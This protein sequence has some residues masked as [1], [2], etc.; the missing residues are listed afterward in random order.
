MEEKEREQFWRRKG[1]QGGWEWSKGTHQRKFVQCATKAWQNVQ[2]SCK[3]NRE[4]QVISIFEKI[5]EEIAEENFTTGPEIAVE[6]LE[7]LTLKPL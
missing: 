4:P 3:H 2:V 1:W 5:N 7:H 6:I